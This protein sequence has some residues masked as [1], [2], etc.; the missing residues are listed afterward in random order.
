MIGG[1]RIPHNGRMN[2]G[3]TASSTNG[4]GPGTRL[5]WGGA[6]AL[7]CWYGGMALLWLVG[8]ESI[9]AHPTPFYALYFPAFSTVAAPLA[10][11]A[12][13]SALAVVWADRTG[14][15]S[16]SSRLRGLAAATA[17]AVLA[18]AAAWRDLAL[19]GL[20]AGRWLGD[21]GA[22]FAFCLAP[23]LLALC[24]VHL[25]HRRDLGGMA[26]GDGGDASKLWRI[27]LGAALF[28]FLFA[29][30]TAMMRGGVEG[31]ARAYHRE[32][33]EY[34]GD[35]GKT[36]TIKAL[37]ERYLD[38][39]PYLSMHAKVH[40]P[41]PVALLWLMS[42][43]AGRGALALSLATAAAGALAAVPLYGWLRRCFGGRAA[44]AGLVL[45]VCCPAVV[46][47]TATSAD[48]L[49]TPFTLG[50]LWLFDRALRDG[51]APSA[52]AAGAGFAVMS[53]LKFSLLGVGV[54]F[55]L[56]G[57]LMLWRARRVAP[58]ALTAALMLGAFLAVHGLVWWWSAFPYIE[59]FQAAKAQFDEDQFHLDRL[60]P[61]YPGWTFRLFFNPAAWF[62]FAGIP[63]SLL[64][65]GGVIKAVRG[66]L[67]FRNDAGGN[68]L[69]SPPLKG[70]LGG[71][72]CGEDVL[73]DT[74]KRER[75][76]GNSEGEIVVFALTALALNF[77]Y[78]ARGEGERSALYLFPFLI[79]PAAWLLAEICRTARSA[80][81]LYATAAFLAL[82]TWL[83]ELYF[84]TY[85]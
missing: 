43:V 7:C 8:V 39:R 27:A 15:G 61:R 69:L 60:T 32:A 11:L 66:T 78:L 64:F 31:I 59:A 85:W 42:Y 72:S 30:A 3:G 10:A 29:C 82:Q 38:V 12:L 26:A 2:G 70:D 25:L 71:C 9:Y 74:A 1:G 73:P 52:L 79:G 4:K 58:V 22:E 20:P 41:G 55:A 51:H 33:Y 68:A 80:A 6:A 48:I 57:L 65:L 49:F 21:A 18:L 56:A 67:R 63:V 34:I 62:Y 40:P 23:L 53:F 47:F 77:L 81:P 83:T 45:Y 54:Y 5:F 14:N 76:A 19:R 37:F 36:G 17:A 24:L 28:L 75:H 13:A 84:F 35:I 46:I 16:A 44:L 50:T